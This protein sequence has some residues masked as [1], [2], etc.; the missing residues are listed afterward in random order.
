MGAS[1]IAVGIVGAFVLMVMKGL[2]STGD[3]RG[4]PG[5]GFVLSDL[6]RPKNHQENR[7]ASRHHNLT[8]IDREPVAV[9]GDVNHANLNQTMRGSPENQLLALLK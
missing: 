4:P 8:E 7:H 6:G 5:G 9:I 2:I 1:L 3:T